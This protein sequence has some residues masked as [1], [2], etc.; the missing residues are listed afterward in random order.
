MPY[1]P[2][3]CCHQVRAALE[4]EIAR[5]A[6][7]EVENRELMQGIGVVST[8]VRLVGVF[9]VA[10]ACV[11]GGQRRKAGLHAA[12][13]TPCCLGEVML[14]CRVFPAHPL[15]HSPTHSLPY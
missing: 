2:N 7:L 10:Y 6:A 11:G 8:Q 3:P 13:H 9:R 5:A 1:D 14:S 12:I 4:V 15:A